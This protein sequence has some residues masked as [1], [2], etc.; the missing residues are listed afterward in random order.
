MDKFNTF[1]I[2][3]DVHVDPPGDHTIFKNLLIEILN[4][5][6][7]VETQTPSGTLPNTTL[8]FY[9]NDYMSCKDVF[10]YLERGRTINS[11]ASKSIENNTDT[12]TYNLHNIM[13]T[14]ASNYHHVYR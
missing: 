6:G 3:Y 5:K 11:I 10:S 2:T 4:Q 9:S 14:P 8:L 7:R 12:Y 1:L 13:I